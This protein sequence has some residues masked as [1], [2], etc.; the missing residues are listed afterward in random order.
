MLFMLKVAGKKYFF[1]L[2]VENSELC[3]DKRVGL[4]IRVVKTRL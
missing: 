3:G 2:F 1:F 4:N